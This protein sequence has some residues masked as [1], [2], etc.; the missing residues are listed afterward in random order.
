M[1]KHKTY[2]IGEYTDLSPIHSE[3]IQWAVV[4]KMLIPIDLEKL[5][6]LKLE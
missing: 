1:N 5:S 3:N 2:I 4:A 6:P